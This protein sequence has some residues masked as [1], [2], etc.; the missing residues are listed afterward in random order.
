MKEVKSRICCWLLCC[1]AAGCADRDASPADDAPRNP[2]ACGVSLNLA[3]S[4]DGSAPD[5]SGTGEAPGFDSENAIRN[6]YVFT[7]VSG[8]RTAYP[9]R[10]VLLDEDGTTGRKTAVLELPVDVREV[11]EMSLYLGANLDDRQAEAFCDGNKAYTLDGTET[12]YNYNVVESF[13]PGVATDGGASSLRTD[14]AMFCTQGR[15]A[16]PVVG[17]DGE[18][19]VVEAEFELRRLVAKVL[20]TCREDDG[21]SGYAPLKEGGSLATNGGWIRLEDV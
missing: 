17:E 15:K 19:V 14:I 8:R 11:G 13:A 10:H 3:F 1:L 9:F 5:A 12:P 16:R 18:R 2:A 20:V 7:E 6:L 21:H 4:V